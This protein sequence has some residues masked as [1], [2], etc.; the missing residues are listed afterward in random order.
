[1][2]PFDLQDMLARFF[3]AHLEFVL[4]CPLLHPHHC[5]AR[6]KAML[7]CFI[8]ER[9][10]YLYAPAA[11][12]MDLNTGVSC[13]LPQQ[14]QFIHGLV[15]IFEEDQY[16][17]FETMLFDKNGLE[18][19]ESM[20]RAKF[21]MLDFADTFTLVENVYFSH[22]L[23]TS[24]GGKMRSVVARHRPSIG[25]IAAEEENRKEYSRRRSVRVGPTDPLASRR[26]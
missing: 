24:K 14:Q 26:R 15:G 19:R 16:V 23:L 3:R 13:M 11:V 8:V 20:V 21:D 5:R 4:G 9:D 6:A 10:R 2:S 25:L 18:T 12:D 22:L 17:C 7:H 1:M